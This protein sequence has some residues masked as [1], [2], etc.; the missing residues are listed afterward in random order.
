MYN[1]NAG[2]F[3][4]SSNI[5]DE[6]TEIETNDI[7]SINYQKEMDRAVGMNNYRLAV[8]LMFLRLLRNL[9]NQN[10]IQYKQDRT[11]FDYMLQLR[12]TR[13]YPDFFRLARSYEYSWYGQF[14]IDKEKYSIIKNEFENFERKLNK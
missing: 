2:L 7:F 10:L 1:S 8:R 12:S 5:A 14:E 9:S 11:N 3:R 13:M 4:K 6:E